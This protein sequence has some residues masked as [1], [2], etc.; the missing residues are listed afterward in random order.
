MNADP[1]IPSASNPMHLQDLHEG[2]F[3]CH[4]HCVCSYR[5]YSEGAISVADQLVGHHART[6]SV[7]SRRGQ[8]GNR[9][10]GPADQDAALRVISPTRAHDNGAGVAHA[11]T[12]RRGRPAMKAITGFSWSRRIRRQL[13]S[14]TDFADQ[15]DRVG[16]RVLR[17]FQGITEWCRRWHPHRCDKGRLAEPVSGQIEAKVPKLPLRK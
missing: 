1:M 2:L 9:G 5:G 6:P 3:R 8:S 4:L 14:A 10:P 17:R 12:G 7:R 16:A 13:G 11:L 15:D